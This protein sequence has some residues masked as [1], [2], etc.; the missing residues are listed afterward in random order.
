[1]S[2]NEEMSISQD[3]IFGTN[4]E[5]QE[6]SFNDSFFTPLEKCVESIGFKGIICPRR[7]HGHSFGKNSSDTFNVI[8]MNHLR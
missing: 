4:G 3:N 8:S 2:F 5:P 1:M 7:S 6:M